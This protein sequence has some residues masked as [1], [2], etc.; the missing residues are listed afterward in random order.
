MR[1]ILTDIL[2]MQIPKGEKVLDIGAGAFSPLEEMDIERTGC[3]AY[4]PYLKKAVNLT[5][6]IRLDARGNIPFKDNSFDCVVCLD[7]IEHIEDR[8]GKHLIEEM[9][10]VSRNSVILLTPEGFTFQDRDNWGMGG[11]YWQTHRAGYDR[12]FFEDLGFTV[13]MMYSTIPQGLRL[14][15]AIIASKV[16]TKREVIS[17]PSNVSIII[18]AYNRV[19]YLKIAIE[20]ALNQTV[21]AKEI[22]VVDDGSNRGDQIKEICIEF[23]VSYLRKENGGTASALNYG[24]KNMKGEWFKWLSDDDYL[25]PNCLELLL[26]KAFETKGKI[27]YSEYFRVNQDGITTS[28]FK[29][30][31]YESQLRFRAAIWHHYIGNGTASLIHRDCFWKVGFFDESL[32]MSDDYDWMLRAALIHEIP[33][34]CLNKATANYRIHLGQLTEIKIKNSFKINKIIRARIEDYLVKYKKDFWNTLKREIKASKKKTL[35]QWIWY[36]R[37]PIIGYLPL[38]NQRIIIK[39]WKRDRL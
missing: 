32:V 29:E 5:H 33:F 19:K 26:K 31:I 21:K 28:L 3:D 6:R 8:Y 1:N 25:E 16:Q 14:T 34:F 39:L 11:D 13:R 4:V 9:E 18:P 37:K 7:V 30:P 23:G 24:I 12:S 27:I 10:R 36:L 22:I 35:L 20:S 38:K 2:E 17:E 15:K